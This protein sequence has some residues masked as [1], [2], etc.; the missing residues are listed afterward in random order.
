MTVEA[1]INGHLCG[2]TQTRQVGQEIMYAINVLADGSGAAT[3][4][5]VQSRV[6]I[7]GIAGTPAEVTTMWDNEQVWWQPL[8]ATQHR[9]FLPVLPRSPHTG[10]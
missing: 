8:A 3:G 6:T 7:I 2:R 10:F 5:G 4:C 1:R 9:L